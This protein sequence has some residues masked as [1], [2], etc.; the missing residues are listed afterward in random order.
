MFYAHACFIHDDEIAYYTVIKDHYRFIYSIDVEIRRKNHW[1]PCKNAR[2]LTESV[3]TRGWSR[4][5]AKR[6]VPIKRKVHDRFWKLIR[7]DANYRTVMDVGRAVFTHARSSRTSNALV[8][9]IRAG[10]S[11]AL[12]PISCS[13]RERIGNTR[14][15]I[16]TNLRAINDASS[17]SYPC[18]STFLI[19]MK[20][21]LDQGIW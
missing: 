11:S 3:R 6:T 21:Y 15:H 8:K 12:L 18:Q 14:R 1:A 7:N 2:T 10:L 16:R 5:T 4:G 13:P 19:I 17:Y 20:E 9:Y